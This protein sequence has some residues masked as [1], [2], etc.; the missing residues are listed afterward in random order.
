MAE[1]WEAGSWILRKQL[2]AL[3]LLKFHKK[4]QNGTNLKK[5]APYYRLIL[6]F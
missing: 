6:T 4:M 2:P 5:K 3:P 1:K